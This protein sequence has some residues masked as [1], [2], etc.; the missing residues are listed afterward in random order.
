MTSKTN[1]GLGAYSEVNAKLLGSPQL[2]SETEAAK[3]DCVEGKP[4]NI[5]GTEPDPL[6]NYTGKEYACTRY[7]DSPLYTPS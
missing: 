6:V 1:E 2:G 7:L 4:G 3:L 5:E